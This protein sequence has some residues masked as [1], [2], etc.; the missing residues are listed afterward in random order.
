MAEIPYLLGNSFKYVTTFLASALNM[1]HGKWGNGKPW[2][3]D[4]QPVLMMYMN[5][6]TSVLTCELLW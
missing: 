6:S 2:M 1:Q 3:P 4:W 5:L